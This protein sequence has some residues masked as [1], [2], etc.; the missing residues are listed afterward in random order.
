MRHTRSIPRPT[1]TQSSRPKRLEAARAG[2]GTGVHA[3]HPGASLFEIG[4]A[5][6]EL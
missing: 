6:Q 3:D 4:L 5:I 2:L 1:G